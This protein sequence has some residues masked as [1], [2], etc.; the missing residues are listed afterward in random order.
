LKSSDATVANTKNVIGYSDVIEERYDKFK[1]DFDGVLGNIVAGMSGR[2]VKNAVMQR[3]PE[4]EWASVKITNSEIG[5][6]LSINHAKRMKAHR[7]KNTV[8]TKE[9]RI[10]AIGPMDEFSHDLVTTYMSHHAEE[11]FEPKR[12]LSR[13]DW[14]SQHKEPD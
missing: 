8:M 5:R 11:V 3:E 9:Q 1:K 2:P 12:I 4:P 10:R 6:A 14:L 13:D 7:G